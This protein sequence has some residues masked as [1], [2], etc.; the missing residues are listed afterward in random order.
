MKIDHDTAWTDA[1]GK[2]ER[3]CD[4]SD[5]HLA[6]MINHVKLEFQRYIGMGLLEALEREAQFRGLS[7]EFLKMA[8]FPYV[9]PDGYW[10]TLDRKAMRPKRLGTKPAR[11]D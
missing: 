5:T 9:G 3:I 7:E 11:R 4:V 1:H 10:M 6:N 8:P 2:S